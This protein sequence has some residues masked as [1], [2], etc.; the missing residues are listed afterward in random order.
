L[1]ASLILIFESACFHEVSVHIK[2]RPV[3][4]TKSLKL[5]LHN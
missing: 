4:H 5:I 2:P 3:E 1:D